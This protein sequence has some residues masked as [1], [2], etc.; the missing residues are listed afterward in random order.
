MTADIRTEKTGKTKNKTAH[1][2]TAHIIHGGQGGQQPSPFGPP[3]TGDQGGQGGK[4][5][6]PKPDQGGGQGGNPINEVPELTEEEK[7][8]YLASLSG[9]RRRA[10]PAHRWT[11]W[12]LR[13]A[14]PWHR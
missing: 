11:P 3:P 7:A 5:E 9:V 10:S 2:M 4:E 6:L 13:L 8:A 14:A 1:F 12:C